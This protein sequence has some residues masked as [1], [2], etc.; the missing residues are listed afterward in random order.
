M[1]FLKCKLL[2]YA[3]QYFTNLAI[4]AGF[5]FKTVAY[6]QNHL[7]LNWMA[8][9]AVEMEEKILAQYVIASMRTETS[10]DGEGIVCTLRS[11]KF[12]KTVTLIFH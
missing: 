11:L 7:K 8:P 2:L 12:I 3:S 6:K 5:F 4:K 9:K 10:T 1:Q